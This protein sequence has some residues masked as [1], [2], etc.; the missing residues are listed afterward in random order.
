MYHYELVS[1]CQTINEVI[2]KQTKILGTLLVN[3]LTI[4]DLAFWIFL[5]P[6]WNSNYR[7]I[8]PLLDR[9]SIKFGSR[10]KTLPRTRLITSGGKSIVSAVTFVLYSTF[11]ILK[12]SSLH[13]EI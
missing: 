12:M 2:L 8:E 13:I 5:K 4:P 7:L 9:L 10:N 11:H 3:V 6:C 1:K